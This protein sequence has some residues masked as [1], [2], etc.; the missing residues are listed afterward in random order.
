MAIGIFYAFRNYI[1]ARKDMEAIDRPDGPLI[2][3]AVWAIESAFVM[4][5][6]FVLQFLAGAL[7]IAQ[8]DGE[9]RS[10]VLI[11]LIG[12]GVVATWRSYYDHHQSA[13]LRASLLPPEGTPGRRATDMSRPSG[14]T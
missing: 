5:L 6:V 8:Q 14:G 13:R 1:E 10:L 12:G 11:C 2:I 3:A 4:L 7:T 9:Y